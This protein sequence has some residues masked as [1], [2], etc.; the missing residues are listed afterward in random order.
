ME[1]RYMSS[2]LT[3]LF[4]EA[5]KKRKEEKKRQEQNT[6]FT[7]EDRELPQYTALETN[8]FR[9]LRFLGEPISMRTKPTS[10]KIIHST[11]ILG[12]DDKNF[13]CI[14]PSKQDDPRWILWRVMNKVMSYTWDPQ[15]GENGA[16][17]Y[18]YKDSHPT[19]FNRVARNNNDHPLE[20]GWRPTTYVIQNVIDR[21][22]QVYKWHKE[23]KKT[24]LLS[25][26]GKQRDDGNIFYE[27][28]YPI[29]LYNSIMEDI[30]EINGDPNTYDIVVQK[31]DEKPYY[32][33]FHPVDDY[34]KILA[35]FDSDKEQLESGIPGFDTSVVE[36]SLTEEELSW[37]RYNIDEAFPVTS[38]RKIQNRLNIFLESVDKAFGTK[39]V[40]ELAEKV[41]EEKKRWEAEGKGQENNVT[42][43]KEK[44]VTS[45]KENEGKEKEDVTE[46]EAPKKRR[47]EKSSNIE[48]EFSVE[49]ILNTHDELKGAKY[50]TPEMKAT[51]KDVEYNNDGTVKTFKYDTDEDILECINAEDDGGCTMASP[52][53]FTH[54]PLCGESFD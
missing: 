19:L 11:F 30:I 43:T 13:R 44:E 45:A 53:S 26:K 16:R 14:F 33:V 3:D 41:E 28:G 51:I 52:A 29:S 4:K 24:L 54:C 10:P 21:D 40:Q 42:V 37:E 38:Y 39:F 1:V 12:D 34:K 20:T 35:K 46:E 2:D 27:P 31:L 6:G 22:P 32:K 49:K 47:R 36:R 23:N 8:G 15:Q 50:L 48:E 18:H 25:K 17:V 9:L 5:A 7:P